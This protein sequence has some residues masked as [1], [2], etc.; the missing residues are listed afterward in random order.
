MSPVDIASVKPQASHAPATSHNYAVGYLKTAIVALVVAH[1]AVLAYHPSA[2]PPPISLL[3][4]PRTWQAFPIID[5]HRAVWAA[6]FATFNDI[7]F[8]A[9]MFFLS[10]LFV[11]NSLT[12][13]GASR[14]LRDRLLRLGLPF[15]PAA[16]VLAP[17]AYYPNLSADARACGFRG[18]PAPMDGLGIVVGRSCVVLL[19]LACVRFD[20][21]AVDKDG[22]EL[23]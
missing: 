19:G 9:L 4:E 2:P 23:D 13:K 1:H 17:L 12:R 7:F 22:A 6:V 14:Y 3:T 11:W 21:H 10:G 16:I 18:F 20:C 8:M 15:I 5:S